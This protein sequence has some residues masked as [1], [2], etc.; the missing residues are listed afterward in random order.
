M[1]YAKRT[2]STH[3]AI[4]KALRKAGC[5]VKDTSRV[6]QGFPDLIVRVGRFQNV[7]EPSQRPWGKYLLME[8]KSPRGTLTADQ[9]KFLAAWPE[10]VIVRS[11]DEALKAVGIG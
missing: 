10:T 11:V 8:V 6:G 4:V 2:D 9:R 3:A 5:Q 7:S 1:G